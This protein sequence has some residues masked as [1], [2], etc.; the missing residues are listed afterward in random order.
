MVR[1]P[2]IWR[3]GGLVDP[4]LAE[5]RVDMVLQEVETY[6]SQCQNTYAQFIATRPIIDLCLEAERHPGSRV[7]KQWW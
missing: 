6:F 1:Q 2:R 3:D 7:A 4:L 5:S